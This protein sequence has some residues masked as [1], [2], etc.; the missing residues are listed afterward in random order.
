ME[1]MR[2]GSNLSRIRKHAMID[3]GV[4]RRVPNKRRRGYIK[5]PLEMLT[6][7]GAPLPHPAVTGFAQGALDPFLRFPIVLDDFAR[8]LVANGEYMDL[9]DLRWNLFQGTQY[10]MKQLTS[11]LHNSF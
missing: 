1:T 8:E 4:S 7:F 3:L 5:I 10:P 11:S 6:E 9:V 2:D